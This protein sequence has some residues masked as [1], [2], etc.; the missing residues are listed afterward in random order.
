MDKLIVSVPEAANL[1]GVSDD[2][3]YELTERGDIPC[4][5]LGRRKLI[6]RQA[7]DALVELAVA[8]FDRSGARAVIG[9]NATRTS[10]RPTATRDLGR[11]QAKGSESGETSR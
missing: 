2:L 11:G 8:D 4:I 6:P 5:R 7:I 3:V 9:R 10:G 1:L